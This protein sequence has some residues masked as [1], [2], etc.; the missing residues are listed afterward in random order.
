MNSKYIVFATAILLLTSIPFA[1]ATTGSYL[2]P[3]TDN[4]QFKGPLAAEITFSICADT[5]TCSGL[6]LGGNIQAAELPFDIGAWTSICPPPA[7]SGGNTNILCGSVA[8]YAWVG[9]SFNHQKFPGN[10]ENFRRAI[11]YLQDYSFIQG[12]ILQGLEGIAGPL[13]TPCAA[14]SGACNPA[15]MTA[16]YGSV[17]DLVR[18]GQELEQVTNDGVQLFCDNAGVQCSGSYSTT[19]EWCL[20]A[21]GTGSGCGSGTL[22]TPKL[23][24]RST[25][26]R[27]LWGAAI[28]SWAAQIGLQISGRG[29]EGGGA[30]SAN[31]FTPNGLEIITPGVYNSGTGYNSVPTVNV[32]AIQADTC[33]MLTYGFIASGPTLEGLLLDYNGQTA[34]SGGVSTGNVYDNPANVSAADPVALF[35]SPTPHTTVN[36]L[37]YT[38][39]AVEFATNTAA[40]N[41]NA[42]NFMQAYALQI[43]TVMAFYEQTLYVNS[44]AG[45]TGFVAAPVTGP[46]ELGGLY[47]TGQT[48]HTCSAT[49]C[50]LNINNTGSGLGGNLKVALEQVSD[51]S[52]LNVV[53]GSNWAWQADVF[54]SIYDTAIA[55]PP[56]HFTDVNYYNDYMT[57]AHSITT[58]ASQTLG[59]GGTWFYFQQPCANPLPALTYPTREGNCQGHAGPNQTPGPLQRGI[60]LTPAQRTITNGEYVTMTIKPGVYFYDGVAVTANDLLFSLNWYNIA[61]GP[62]MPDQNSPATGTFAG[63]FGLVAA[64]LLSA[65]GLPCS[66]NCPTIQIYIGSQSFWGLPSVITGVLPSHVF[67]YFNADHSATSGLGTVDTSLPYGSAATAFSIQGAPHPPATSWMWYL[68]NLEIGSGPYYLT[69]WNTAGGT[70]VDTANPFYFNPNWQAQTGYTVLNPT[71]GYTITSPLI[72]DEYNP[73]FANINCGPAQPGPILP[74]TSGLCQITNALA[75]VSK[76]KVYSADGLTLERNLKL[77]K[78]VLTGQYSFTLPASSQLARLNGLSCAILSGTC[79]KMTAGTY[80]AVLQTTYAFHGQTRTWYQIFGFTYR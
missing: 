80:Y 11:Q 67:K 63:P 39:S 22:F 33:G 47:F 30:A 79:Y 76:V 66:V 31:C 24:Y 4:S 2:L 9:L 32:T 57:S 27:N 29:P 3:A 41:T 69:S 17:Q 49:S 64:H 56:G 5:A 14:Y 37:D 12:T 6:L 18:A 43:P 50:D 26:Y 1:S 44:A 20:G 15:P 70:G 74:G 68:P 60:G 48:A 38:T 19:S 21:L 10:N 53:Y 52:G 35:P 65:R 34:G 40:V 13:P 62:N 71:N 77:T 75:G 46:N 23:D 55:T 42:Q 54:G 8:S 73:T 58:F 28:I 51:A 72:I 59:T 25:L 61:A 45:W 36:N 7:G 78:N 16:H